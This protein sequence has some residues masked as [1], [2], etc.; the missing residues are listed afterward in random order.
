M[1][2]L[3]F[4]LAA[5]NSG[6]V[7]DITDDDP[8]DPHE[9]DPVASDS[10]ILRGN[11]NESVN[12]QT[13]GE[14]INVE[15]SK[16]ILIYSHD[17]KVVN[18]DDDEFVLEI[19]RENP[20]GIAFVDEEDN[21]IGYLT[22]EDGFDSIPSS[23]IDEETEEI[24][25]GT[26]TF[27]GEQGTPENN[28]LGEEINISQEEQDLLA[29]SS[30]FFAATFRSA[31]VIESIVKGEIEGFS[32][33]F[34]YA[35]EHM[36]QWDWDSYNRV[37]YDNNMNLDHDYYDI[38]YP[39][40]QMHRFGVEV[41]G[42]EVPEDQVKLHYPDEWDFT[43]TTEPTDSPFYYHFNGKY[44]HHFQDA[45]LDIYSSYATGGKYLFDFAGEKEIEVNIPDDLYEIGKENAFIV[46]PTYHLTEN[47]EGI[48][49]IEEI[50]WE[51]Y[52]KSGKPI[53]HDTAKSI[54]YSGGDNPHADHPNSIHMAI[55]YETLVD[56]EIV[57]DEKTIDVPVNNHSY[58]LERKIA[59]K[60]VQDEG[61]NR[62]V[63]IGISYEDLYG[64]HY[65]VSFW[66][67]E[68]DYYEDNQPER[69]EED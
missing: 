11:F 4:S 32:L 55:H 62:L 47:D 50:S 13:L 63:R 41:K 27:D 14:N 9:E 31:D 36:M 34:M 10:V 25:F 24:D 18:I 43:D 67:Y 44:S 28:P 38:E 37:S 51:Y 48:D 57:E 1:F 69:P 52:T 40:F 35:Y 2:L 29:A 45:N 17:F 39:F 5:C 19:D 65:H 26:I 3:V 22:L 66:G 16:V 53:S 60:D 61:V 12:V 68:N 58:R 49:V 6:V 8:S 20:A 15:V 46:V 42:L 33:W 30:S 59:W 23:F 56:G 54:I 64:I 7:P 21:Y